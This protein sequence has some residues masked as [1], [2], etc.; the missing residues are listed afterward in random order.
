MQQ[1]KQ[2]FGFRKSK[3]TKN[4]TGAVLGAALLASVGVAQ[5]DTPTEGHQPE[6]ITE[7][8]KVTFSVNDWSNNQLPTKY[9]PIG[10]DKVEPATSVIQVGTSGTEVLPKNSYIKITQE[11]TGVEFL[12]ANT[13]VQV[14]RTSSPVNVT[15]RETSGTTSKSVT[16]I[17]ISGMPAGTVQSYTAAFNSMGGFYPVSTLTR[18]YELYVDGQKV[19]TKT[20]K[21]TFKEVKPTV[22]ATAS[23]SHTKF[24][25][26]RLAGELGTEEAGMHVLSVT[27]NVSRPVTLQI[28]VPD[29]VVPVGFKEASDR[30]MQKGLPNGATF[31]DGVLTIPRYYGNQYEIP[32]FSPTP[33]VLKKPLAVDP[34]NP[35]TKPS[36]NVTFHVTMTVPTDPENNNYTTVETDVTT[37]EF[38]SDTSIVYGQLTVRD[39]HSPYGTENDPVSA[40]TFTSIVHGSVQEY[41]TKGSTVMDV[42]PVLMQLDPT[43]VIDPSGLTMTF[44]MYSDESKEPLHFEIR[45]ADTN[46]VLVAD[47][48]AGVHQFGRTVSEEKTIDIPYTKN[49]LVVPKAKAGG[50]LPQIY[51]DGTKGTTKI[52]Y[53]TDVKGLNPQTYRDK[54]VANAG[55]PLK[56]DTSSQLM[57]TK[58]LTKTLLADTGSTFVAYVPQQV[59]STSAQSTVYIGQNAQPSSILVPDPSNP[60]RYKQ[61]VKGWTMTKYAQMENSANGKA[62]DALVKALEK[63]PSEQQPKVKFTLPE[64]IHLISK[65]RELIDGSSTSVMQLMSGVGLMAEEGLP[66]GTYEVPYELDLSTLPNGSDYTIVGAEKGSKVLKGT[67]KLTLYNHDKISTSSE[68]KVGSIWRPYKLDV[69]KDAPFTIRSNVRIGQK[70]TSQFNALVYIPKKGRDNTTIDTFL[71]GP[72]GYGDNNGPI[73]ADYKWAIEYTTDPITGDRVADNKKLK[74]TKKVDDYSKV[75]AVRFV[76][77]APMPLMSGYGGTEGFGLQ[78]LNFPLVTHDEITPT[79]VA[80]YRTSLVDSE[81]SYDSDFVALA[82][83]NFVDHDKV[84]ANS[85]GSVRQLFKEEGTNKELAP[86][87]DTGMKPV[88]EAL[89]LTHPQTIQFEGKTYEFIRQDKVDPTKIPDAFRETITY[90][91]K[92]VQPKGNVVQKFVDETGKEIKAST[93]TGVKPVNEAIK[94]EHPT[95]IRFEDNDYAFVRQDKVDPTKIVEGTQTITY[96]YRKVEKPVVKGNVVQKF[97]DEAGKEIKASTDT[98]VKPVDEAIKLEHPTTIHFEDND[99]TFVRQDKVDPTKIVEGTQTI[100]YIYKK[101]EK[102]V[103]KPV[104]KG[105]VVQKFVD[106]TGKEIKASTDTGVKP[107]DE[108]IKLEHPTTIHFEDNDYTFVKQDKV[109]PTKIVEGTQTIT[110]IYRKVEKPVVKGNVVQKF[111]DEAGKEIKAST[112]TGVKPVDEAIKLE[113]P[114]TIHF[115]DNDYTFVKQD[116]V[117]PTKIVEGTQ[118]ITYIYKQVEKPVVKGNV[119]QKFVDEAGKEIKASTDTGVKPVDEAIKLEHPT[120]IHF[121]DNDYTFVKQDKVDPTKIVEGTQTITYIYK[122]VEK[123]V[124]KGNVVQKFVDEAGKEIKASTDTGVKPV[125][126]AIKLEH[127]T[128]IHFEDNDYSFVKQDKVD[129]TKIVE[130]TQTITYIYRKVENPVKKVT[131]IWV[132]EKGDV[133]KPRTDGEQP[134]E[135]FDGYE[136][137][138]TDKDKDGNTTHIYRPIEKPVKKVTTIWVTEKGEVLKPRTDGE[139]PKENFD[140]YEFVRTDKDKD[141]NITHIYRPI[142]KVTTIWVTE[143]GDVLKPRT[144]GEQPKE[145]FDGYEFVRTDKDNDGNTTHVYRKVEKPVEKPVKKVTTIWVTEKG[146]VLKPRTDGEQPKENFDGYEFVR[147]DKDEDGNT[148]HIY[149]PIEKPVKKVTTIWVTEKG[150]VLKPRTDGEQPKE[151]FDGYEFVRT[152]KDKDGNTTHI[153]RPIEKPVKKVTTIWVTE[154]GEVLKPRTDGEQPKEHFDGYEFVRTDKDEDGNTNHIYRKVEKPVEK[155]VK[156]VTTI[157]VTETGEVLKPRIDGEQPKLDFD[158]YEF[159]RTDKDED[160]NVSHIY[161]KVEK[162][163]EKPVK[164]VYTSWVT[165]TGEVLK[166]RTEGEQPKENFDGYEFVRTDKDKDGNTN[167][168]YRKVEKPVEKHQPVPQPQKV[169]TPKELPKSDTPKELPKTGDASTS[170][171]LVSIALLAAGLLAKPRKRR[172]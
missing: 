20:F 166:P 5:A 43:G 25:G 57:D 13:D 140:G 90:F 33:E 169:E 31:E 16:T 148:T 76:L 89:S 129:P 44:S 6:K 28:Q 77:E 73:P 58:V 120:T 101:V 122:K 37:R 139:Q 149:R 172:N 164:K 78:K 144:D 168:I 98:G 143:K 97:V 39:T 123:P 9:D 83:P 131:T 11:A 132:T 159:V 67:L 35:N 54:V 36:K 50:T 84:L 136:F 145:N 156:K 69:Q 19:D 127:P 8:T 47:Y 137:V 18:T 75:T 121:E 66:T 32:I 52:H 152:D 93:D 94:L 26:G 170:L 114:T 138:R 99:Y 151:N 60:G 105:N 48:T 59:S 155:P 124:V 55:K 1:Q 171:G 4:L 53:R 113:H 165:E 106:E 117:D 150:D 71:T 74:F 102:P 141:G 46:Q 51:E 30:P 49:L 7:K 88:G 82:G 104:V 142:K 125:D 64:G 23:E 79:S 45:N 103:E 134:K 161:K 116:K 41:A 111:V 112:D 147:T 85:K 110:Y 162:P 3:L 153:Y 95:T 65:S 70:V 72:V 119:V 130:G 61:P 146:D 108:S 160:G 163:V 62:S 42:H 14:Q 24:E 12:L 21:N 118:T 158:G 128:T 157:W 135:N 34:K 167:H 63:I 96:I 133:L 29:G 109:D 38:T 100:T 91:Y 17:D 86:Q 27:K 68:I 107:V 80:Y 92:E 126:E 154:K 22:T 2:I 10:V 87:T 81:H 56:I 40:S 115:E 15:P